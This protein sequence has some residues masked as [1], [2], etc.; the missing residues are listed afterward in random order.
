M[1]MSMKSSKKTVT[2]NTSVEKK[3]E[4][5]VE[6]SEKELVGPFDGPT[7]NVNVNLGATIPLKSYSNVKVGVSLTLP[8]EPTELGV[9]NAFSNAS[10]WCFEKIDVLT[11]KALADEGDED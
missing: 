4:P 6:T 10:D 8:C 11:E 1:A 5:P 9:E 2:K 3:G 7:A